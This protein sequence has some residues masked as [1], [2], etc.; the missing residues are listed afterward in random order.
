[1]GERDLSVGV[2]ASIQTH[3]SLANW[4]PHLHLLVTD[5]GFRPDGTSVRRELMEEATALGCGGA[6]RRDRVLDVEPQEPWAADVLAV[7]GVL[8]MNDRCPRTIAR[9]ETHDPARSIN[10][11]RNVLGGIRLRTLP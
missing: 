7:A 10:P 2:V 5:G 6:V 3:G 8:V 11:N 4:H 9:G 1:M